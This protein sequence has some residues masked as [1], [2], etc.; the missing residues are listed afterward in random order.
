M[1]SK[2]KRM[3]RG[4]RHFLSVL[5]IRNIVCMSVF[6]IWGTLM[7]EALFSLHSLRFSLLSLQSLKID[8]ISCYTLGVGA[9]MTSFTANPLEAKKELKDMERKIEFLHKWTQLINKADSIE[10]FYSY[11]LHTMKKVLNYEHAT[12]TLESNDSLR[13][14]GA[15]GETLLDMRVNSLTRK[16]PIEKGPN[17]KRLPGTVSFPQSGNSQLVVPI[18]VADDVI[19]TLSVESEEANAFDHVDQDLLKLI[20]SHLT[21][22]IQ[23]LQEKNRR[24]SL[25][26][27]DKL[28]NQ[29]LAI[30]IHE[31]NTL[32]TPIKLDLEMLQTNHYGI[33]EGEQKTKITDVLENVE[34]VLRLVGELREV[35]KLRNGKITVEKGE[36]DLADTIEKALSWYKDILGD[37][38]ILLVKD[39]QKPLSNRCDEDKIIR[40]IQNLVENAIDFT[41]DRIWI[42]GWDDGRKVGLSVRDNGVGI[43]KAEQKTIFEP[44]SQGK[45]VLRSKNRLF[46]GIGIGLH[47]C[48][49]I[50]EAH[51]G[52]LYVKSA[53][54]KGSTFICILPK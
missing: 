38:G 49:Q 37:E 46:G 1:R 50:M 9:F 18:T 28:R 25:Q 48:Q 13:V 20:A 27:L 33:L 45:E 19:G 42:K 39:I 6:A 32:I 16:D 53:S 7:M 30:V 43:S 8:S 35:S 31:I 22:A 26:R 5:R 29:F 11:T 21:L 52:K 4:E 3:L 34:R 23:E 36:C 41:K 14:E 2:K 51:H 10:D 44:F 24:T 54:G 47:I 12:M 17:G 40:V 15:E